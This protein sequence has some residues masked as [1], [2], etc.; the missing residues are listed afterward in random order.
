MDARCQM[1]E[2]GEREKG[3]EP[4]SPPPDAAAHHSLM[5]TGRREKL[6]KTGF[7]TLTDDNISVEPGPG[8]DLSLARA[9]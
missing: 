6:I 9:E 3:D 2:R 5:A 8:F 7:Q 1:Q 4:W